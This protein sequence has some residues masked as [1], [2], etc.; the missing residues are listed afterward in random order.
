MIYIIKR[1]LLQY[2]R[3]K[4]SVFFSLMGVFV[5][6]GLYFLFLGD[7]M[8]SEMP[9]EEGADFFVDSWI[10]SGVIGVAPITTILGAY[11]N[12]VDDRKRNIYKD[13]LA[14]P[15]KR[16]KLAGG[17]IMS[18]YIIG[19]IMSAITFILAEIYIIANGGDLLPFK[20]LVKVV[21]IILIYSLWTTFVFYFFLSFLKSLNAFI[22]VSTVIGTMVGF[23]TGVYIPIGNLPSSV[24]NVIKAFPPSQ[25]AM[26]I[27]QN[28]IEPAEL[29]AFKNVPDNI[30][31]NIR[32]SLG[33]IFKFGDKEITWWMTIL[34][35]LGTG[36]IFFV[37]SLWSIS[38][39]KNK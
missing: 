2:F 26:L 16:S 19:L 35:L 12:M 22:A 20:N 7:V 37:L 1:N 14:S 33:V 21:G 39:K 18:S 28:M 25:A 13:F 34:Y 5:I 3:D 9:F 23:L 10:M 17:Y 8:K 30:L 27:R 11:G 31:D 4:S 24:Q 6:I 36:L 15:V 38:N 29:I 32:L